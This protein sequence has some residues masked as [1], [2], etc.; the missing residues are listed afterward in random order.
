[1]KT[2]QIRRTLLC[3]I[4][5]LLT[6]AT[7]VTFA[8]QQQALETVTFDARTPSQVPQKSSY[9]GGASLSPHGR[10]L[11]LNSMYLT[12]NGKP[13]LPVMGE[14][15]F[16]RVPQSDWEPELLKMKTAG[17][18][19]V[20]TYLFWIHHEEI[21]DQFDWSGQRNLR[22]FLQLCAKYHLY[23]IV[24]VGPW[25][26][27]EAR[28][29]GLPDWLLKKGPTRRKDPV[30]MHYVSRYFGQIAQQLHGLL[31]KNGGPVIGIQLEN[32]YA[33]R[34]PGQGE[35]YIL[36]L[37]KLVVDDG[38]DVPFYTVT[39]WDNAVIPAGKVLPVYGGYPDAPWDAARTALPPNEVY[40]FRFGSR[41]SGNM[42]MQGATSH[43]VPQKHDAPQAPFI[44]AEIGGGVQDT[45]H[46]RPVIAPDDVAAMMPVMLGS[47]VNLYGTYM[48]QGGENPDGKLTTLQESQSTSYPTD[49]PVKS[50]DFQAP[51]GEFGQERT[52]FRK[53]KVFNYFLNDFGSLLAPMSVHAPAVRPASPSDFS[54]L[55]AAV[56]SSGRRGFLFVN[57]YVRGSTMPAHKSVQFAIQLPGSTLRIPEQPM[58]IPSGAYFIWPF[59]F[60][61]GITTLRLTTTQL[62]T[63]VHSATG[64]TYF[65]EQI[66][67]VASQ[68]VLEDHRDL[69]ISAAGANILRHNC[70][71]SIDR[72]P[73]GFQHPIVLRR[74]TGAET[75]IIVLTQSE[76]EHAWKVHTPESQ[77][78]VET[79]QNF[80]A[81]GNG[82][83]LLSQETPHC[84]FSI[85]PDAPGQF[86][87]EGLALAQTRSGGV[88]QFSGSVPG[89]QFKLNVQKAQDAS[90]APPVPLGPPLSWRPQGVAMAPDDSAFA[91]AAQWNLTVTGNFNQPYLSNLFLQIRYTG[92][93]ARLASGV[94]LLD[95]NFYNGAPWTIGL[96]RFQSQLNHGPLT[97]SVLPLRK[98]API[99]LEH[100][101][102]PDFTTGDQA[103]D[104]D[105]ITLAP[106]YRFTIAINSSGRHATQ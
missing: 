5:L 102:W 72:I 34:G 57:N 61:L 70:V 48:F 55:R 94:T 67:G 58:D 51:L 50:Y 65:F 37:K 68:L 66:P 45:Y 21:E 26:H 31:W 17:V 15:H 25:A 88:A 81:S 101:S 97:L 52:S 96:R 71:V 59:N 6:A 54:P 98:D 7:T 14:F 42:G 100:Q 46:R 73:T 60:D 64:D 56:R 84:T 76:A 78:L 29:G 85:Y 93:V 35:E 53:L 16:S 22:A 83:V 75:R 13:W 91:H 44:T 69:S 47:G 92:D 24:R 43:N 82:F 39:G 32:E 90:P 1:M 9:V 3:S 87:A 40:L 28:N 12:L 103:V 8:A 99:F 49:V 19:I 86:T 18:Q 33:S 77:F 74:S 23:V 30:F 95:D 11:G 20:A 62:F 79:P 4:A 106:E 80:Y 104:L 89:A 105:N 10:A 38:L 63:R 36:A 27:G 2:V 41:V